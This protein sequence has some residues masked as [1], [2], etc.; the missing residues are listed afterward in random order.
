MSVDQVSNIIK[1]SKSSNATGHDDVSM[2]ILKKVNKNIAPHLTHLYNTM[3]R[4]SIFPEIMKISRISPIKKP[5]T[6]GDSISDFRPINN[7]VI[8]FIIRLKD[9]R[10]PAETASG[11][12]VTY[13]SDSPS[14]RPPW[15]LGSGE[16]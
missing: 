8:I 12:D 15:L 2:S 6:K 3:I 7:L 5:D 10:N 9:W 1:M 14:Q 13:I 4:T 16:P 11:R